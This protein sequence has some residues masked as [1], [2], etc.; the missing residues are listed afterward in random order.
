MSFV[1]IVFFIHVQYLRTMEISISLINSYLA[2][3]FLLFFYD[4]VIAIRCINTKTNN[5]CWK[6]IHVYIYKLNKEFSNTLKNVSRCVAVNFL[7]YILLM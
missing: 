3:C 7:R 6:N 4:N 2:F 1:Y 5:K